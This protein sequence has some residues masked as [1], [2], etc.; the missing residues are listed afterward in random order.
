MNETSHARRGR[1]APRQAGALEQMPW[2]IPLNTD[3][4]T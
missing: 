4:P 3:A 2:R 1:R